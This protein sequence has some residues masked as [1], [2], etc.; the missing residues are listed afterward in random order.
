MKIVQIVPR[1]EVRLHAALVTKEADIRKKGLAHFI[2][3][4]S[5]SGIR[6]S[7]P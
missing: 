7:E 2:A 5:R 6:P 1:E 3:R 4:L